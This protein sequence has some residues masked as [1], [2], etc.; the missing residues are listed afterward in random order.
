MKRLILLLIIFLCSFQASSAATYYVNDGAVSAGDLCSSAAVS[1]VGISGSGTTTV[2]FH[3]E[4]LAAIITTVAATGDI[5]QLDAMSYT[6]SATAFTITKQIT[7]K[8]FY[9][10]SPATSGALRGAKE[11]QLDGDFYFDIQNGDVTISGLFI[12]NIT[13]STYINTISLAAFAYNAVSVKNN[14][15]SGNSMGTSTAIHLAPTTLTLNHVVEGNFIGSYGT[16]IFALRTQGVI[17]RDNVISNLKSTV[18]NVGIFMNSAENTIIRGNSILSSSA[19][20]GAGIHLINTV[21]GVLANNLIEQNVVGSPGAGNMLA[22]IKIGNPT[23]LLETTGLNTIS[24]NSLEVDNIAIEVSN[25]DFSTNQIMIRENR[26]RGAIFDLRVNDA[27]TSATIDAELNSWSSHPNQP[28]YGTHIVGLTLPML[29]TPAGVRCGVWLTSSTDSD[30]GTRGFQPVKE[31]EFNEGIA[32]FGIQK[33]FDIIPNTWTLHVQADAELNNDSLLVNTALNKTL[34]MDSSSPYPKI[35]KLILNNSLATV[36]L[37]NGHLEIISTLSLL[38]GSINNSSATAQPHVLTSGLVVRNLG[39]LTNPI[40]T[41]HN[42]VSY[43]YN[44]VAILAEI[45]EMPASPIVINDLHIKGT[46][47]VRA[48]HSIL[49]EGSLCFGSISAGKTL[50]MGAHNFIMTPTATVSGSSPPNINSYIATNGPGLFTITQTIATSGSFRFPVGTSTEYAPFLL[51]NNSGSPHSGTHSARAINSIVLDDPEPPSSPASD[52]VNVVWEMQTSL[53]NYNLSMEWQPANV[54]GVWE[55][56]QMR[57]ARHNITTS[58]SI[59]PSLVPLAITPTSASV[60][61]GLTGGDVIRYAVFERVR[62]DG[63]ST[64]RSSPDCV[65]SPANYSY[66]L[67]GN[68]PIGTIIELQMSDAAGSFASPTVVASETLATSISGDV[69]RSFTGVAVP[70]STPQGTGYKFRVATVSGTVRISNEIGPY[71]I[72]N[73]ININS[74]AI[75][76]TTL[77]A[78]ETIGGSFFAAGAFNAGNIFTFQLSDASGS[79]ASPVTIG[80]LPYAGSG[81]LTIPTPTL[82]IPA[83]T[84]SGAG[85]RVRV[86]ASDPISII[87]SSFSLD[88]FTIG[89]CITASIAPG[90]VCSG[91]RIIVNFTATG[92]FP[93]GSFN[94]FISSDGFATSTNISTVPFLTSGFSGTTADFVEGDLVA[95]PAGSYQIRIVFIDAA[96]SGFSNILPLVVNPKPTIM[97]V[98]GFSPPSC[99]AGS[100]RLEV[101]LSS[102]TASPYSIDWNN[103][104]TPDLSGI[105]AIGPL[106]NFTPVPTGLYSDFTV[107]DANGCKGS[108]SVGTPISIVE[109]KP[110]ITT[111]ELK[112]PVLC[113]DTTATLII[114]LE[115]GTGLYAVDLDD[116]GVYDRTTL[117][118][119]DKLR[120]P[121]GPSTRIGRY[122]RVRRVTDPLCASLA[123]DLGDTLR[124]TPRPLASATLSVVADDSVVMRDETTKIR[125]WPGQAGV[126]YTLRNDSTG[127]LIGSAKI[128][129]G[130]DTVVFDTDTITK[131]TLYSVVARHPSSLC[132]T[133]LSKRVLVKVIPGI[134]ESDSLALVALYDSTCG[135]SWSDAW[136]LTH[137]IKTWLGVSYAKGRVIA[138]NLE[139]RGLCNRIPEPIYNLLKLKN[140]NVADNALDYASLEPLQMKGLNSFLYNPQAEVNE[141]LDTL[142]KEGEGIEFDVRIGGEHNLY[143]W[144]KNDSLLTIPTANTKRLSLV[145][146]IPEDAGKYVCEVRNSV[147]PDIVIKRKAIYLEVIS[148]PYKADSVALVAIFGALRTDA[149]VAP[150]GDDPETPLRDWT[151][152]GMK[153]SRVTSV[154]WPNQHLEGVLP[155]VFGGPEGALV[156]LEYFNLFGNKLEEEIPSTFYTLTRLRH[157]DLSSNNL[158]GDIPDAISNF[159]ELEILWLSGNEFSALPIGIGDLQKLKLLDV[160]ENPLGTLPA[161]IANMTSLRAFYANGIQLKSWPSAYNGLIALEDLYLNDNLLGN[162]S[163]DFSKHPALKRFSARNNQIAALPSSMASRRFELVDVSSNYL[164]FDDLAVLRDKADQFEY[165]PQADLNTRIDTLVALDSDFRLKVVAGGTD[166]T[167][168]W[169]KNGAVSSYS[170]FNASEMLITDFKESDAGSYLAEV[171]NAKFPKLVLIRKPIIAQAGC[172][173]ADNIV[174]VALTPNLLCDNEPTKVQLAVLNASGFKVQWMLNGDKLFAATTDSLLAKRAGIYQVEMRDDKGCV[175]YTNSVEVRVESAPNVSIALV[176]GKLQPDT[177]SSDW[178]YQWYKDDKPI[179]GA[180]QATYTPTENGIYALLVVNKL[181]CSSFSNKI[182]NGVTGLADQTIS[183]KTHIYPN[184]TP[185]ELFVLLPETAIFEDE[186][187]VY[188]LLGKSHQVELWAKDKHYLH[189]NISKLTSGTYYIKIST[190]AGLVLKTFV[191][192]K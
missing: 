95:T 36:N 180:N 55:I 178:A 179:D 168:L 143:A 13:T 142:V 78:G 150:W 16:G 153:G 45:N 186:F 147:V 53:P 63:L 15:F 22:G 176:D 80:T 2:P 144:Y 40:T 97:N 175:A 68:Y 64:T 77:C 70:P 155:S 174:L 171:R 26:L 114:T 184:P 133:R 72:S 27:I 139:N 67:H 82:T 11:T 131:T 149:S 127:S 1:S 39:G 50:E 86:V 192:S 87:P 100:G 88:N 137:P 83:S 3:I 6:F 154:N 69:S 42:G 182:L 132:T 25:G 23:P 79:F 185:S 167:Y 44:N 126:A 31:A 112:Q 125:I 12:G 170:G 61:S 165:S 21:F 122:L 191:V 130:G 74:G 18:G 47:R 46:A 103:D 73:C 66:V 37:I 105:G 146:V 56:F 183:Q 94:V 158:K 128:A 54:V 135:S 5:I 190:S 140:V 57:I 84:P 134:Y 129:L 75:T 89:S 29:S 38:A 118:L 92:V 49:M 8:G 117:S 76:P 19:D 35:D 123:Y 4:D 164:E 189:L 58:T 161:S 24:Q 81:A 138:L 113:N 65:T 124:A 48:S 119:L 62:I 33:A 32:T 172:K 90:S 160:S 104:G 173:L 141:E 93:T 177:T 85:Y 151:G 101:M 41:P 110:V 163:M 188:D 107:T 51:I 115:S 145:A 10:D 59:F 102:S 28:T 14:V 136:V 162:L 181:G 187:S 71:S 159:K 34:S 109:P 99:A 17:I 166:N 43:H 121:L 96:P 111:V 120:I 116:N 7:I 60:S 169:Y 156:M 98:V 152:I 52:F 106:I 20:I 30:G 108:F 148:A 9:S 91:G 157:L